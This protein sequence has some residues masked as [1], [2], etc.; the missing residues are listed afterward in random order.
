VAWFGGDSERAFLTTDLGI[1]LR[2]IRDLLSQAID[3]GGRAI[4]KPERGV[5]S[6]DTLRIN[7][8]A[9]EPLI[10]HIERLDE[11]WRLHHQIAVEGI[12]KARNASARD[13]LEIL[14][15]LERSLRVLALGP[16]GAA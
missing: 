12:A 9:I 7:S 13:V 6:I 10:E 3:E 1:E 8:A 14:D 11:R 4:D 16:A 2:A 15:E 5:E